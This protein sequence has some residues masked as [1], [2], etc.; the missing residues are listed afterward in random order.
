MVLTFCILG[1]IESDVHKWVW[2]TSLQV[3]CLC[4]LTAA[5]FNY[6][7]Q[8]LGNADVSIKGPQKEQ[9]PRKTSR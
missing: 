6:Q 9:F 3:S 4:Y 5:Q 8:K 2:A 7:K 1:K